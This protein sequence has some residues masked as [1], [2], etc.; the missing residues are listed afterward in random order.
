MIGWNILVMTLKRVRRDDVTKDNS[1][2]SKDR[3][4]GEKYSDCACVG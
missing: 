4:E 1:F 3:R 2:M